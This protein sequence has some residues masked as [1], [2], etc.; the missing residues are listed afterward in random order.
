[1]LGWLRGSRERDDRHLVKGA[2]LAPPEVDPIDELARIVGEAQG[3][4]A[5]D[6]RRFEHQAKEHQTA[7][8]R[9]RGDQVSAALALHQPQDHV[10][11][12]LGPRCPAR[13]AGRDKAVERDQDP[14]RTRYLTQ[15]DVFCGLPSAS[16]SMRER[17]CPRG[18]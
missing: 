6:E 7:R 11:V 8:A 4:D 2:A 13:Q 15:P 14:R 16:E 5:T 10:A 3:R 1:M 17:T 18:P 9:L 12:A